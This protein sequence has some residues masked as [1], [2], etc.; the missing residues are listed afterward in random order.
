MS[1]ACGWLEVQKHRRA[2]RSSQRKVKTRSNPT[3]IA[4]LDQRNVSANGLANPAHTAHLF[5]SLFVLRLRRTGFSANAPRAERVTLR[6]LEQALRQILRYG[7][8]LVRTIFLTI[9]MV[10]IGAVTAHA[11]THHKISHHDELKP[12]SLAKAAFEARNAICPQRVVHSAH[13]AQSKDQHAVQSQ[14]SSHH[15]CCRWPSGS[16]QIPAGATNSRSRANVF[17]DAR[18]EWSTSKAALSGSEPCPTGNDSYLLA[19]KWRAA[20]APPHVLHRLLI[21]TTGRFRI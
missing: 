13:H 2:K 17:S 10:L 7:C 21:L 15:G 20:T 11:H 9:L 8:R 3:A 5:G 18:F 4:S 6:S 16:A 12:A 14:S 1:D 19:S